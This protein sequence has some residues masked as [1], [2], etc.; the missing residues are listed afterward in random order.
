MGTNETLAERLNA[1]LDAEAAKG[2]EHTYQ[3]LVKAGLINRKFQVTRLS[4]GD[5]EPEADAEPSPELLRS[6]PAP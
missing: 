3:R 1:L 2:P 5:A 6:A 4:G